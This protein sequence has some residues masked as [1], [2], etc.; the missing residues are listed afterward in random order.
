VCEAGGAAAARCWLPRAMRTPRAWVLLR[1]E[2]ARRGERRKCSQTTRPRPP[3]RACEG[4]R[5]TLQVAA[6]RALDCHITCCALASARDENAPCVGAAA[7]RARASRRST[8]KFSNHATAASGSGVRGREG[9]TLSKSRRRGL[10]PTKFGSWD[11]AR[12]S[13][14]T[15]ARAISRDKRRFRGQSLGLQV[16][17]A[18]KSQRLSSVVSTMELKNACLH[19][20][21]RFFAIDRAE[22]RPKRWHACICSMHGATGTCGGPQT[23]CEGASRR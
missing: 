20:I 10:S 22:R 9:A 19:H 14:C 23:T 5:A 18:N 3:G 8:H 21:D 16:G 12:A 7:R 6:A 4:E 17:R 13:A 11:A 2:L 15:Y 1:G